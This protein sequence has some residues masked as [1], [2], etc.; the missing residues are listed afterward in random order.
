MLQ[1]TKSKAAFSQDLIWPNIKRMS[2]KPIK[3]VILKH[4]S[5]FEYTRCFKI[6]CLCVQ[7][8]IEFFRLLEE[9]VN[10]FNRLTENLFFLKQCYKIA[11]FNFSDQVWLVSDILISNE[12]R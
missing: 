1:T 4:R 9:L 12:R 7:H 8:H 2:K 5:L 3:N 11:S 6:L 10:A